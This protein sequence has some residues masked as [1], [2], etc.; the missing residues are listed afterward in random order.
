MRPCIVLELA[1]GGGLPYGVTRAVGLAPIK[2]QTIIV[3][4]SRMSESPN[5]TT[6]CCAR[7]HRSSGVATSGSGG[8]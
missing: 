1:A 2:R 8:S 4:Q 7:T 5:S 6:L 3:N